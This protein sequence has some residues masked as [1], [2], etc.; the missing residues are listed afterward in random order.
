MFSRLL[1]DQLVYYLSYSVSLAGILQ[2]LFL[3]KFVTK[4]YSL[5]FDSV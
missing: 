5:K 1:D 3:Y 2:L 4:Y